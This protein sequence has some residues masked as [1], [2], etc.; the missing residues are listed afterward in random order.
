VGNFS[1]CVFKKDAGYPKFV[2]LFL[3]AAMCATDQTAT[4]D[5]QTTAPEVI[6]LYSTGRVTEACS[7]N[8]S[9]DGDPPPPLCLEEIF[10]QESERLTV[11]PRCSW[12]QSWS[13]C[14]VAWATFGLVLLVTTNHVH[15]VFLLSTVRGKCF[16]SSELTLQSKMS[17][18]SPTYVTGYHAK[19]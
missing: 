18:P 17:M 3:F 4:E 2:G 19:I 13:S 1:L 12:H 14:R 6:F 15:N 7:G 5:T 8:V 9:E 10:L 11:F 16:R